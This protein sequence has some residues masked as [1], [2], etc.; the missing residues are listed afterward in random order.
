M[1]A[2]DDEN[3][4]VNGQL[5]E[6]PSS[7]SIEESAT[8][9]DSDA[10]DPNDRFH[11]RTGVSCVGICRPCFAVHLQLA[12]LVKI[13]CLQLPTQQGTHMPICAQAYHEPGSSPAF[14]PD[15]HCY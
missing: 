13:A 15:C 6:E 9:E 8:E 1:V 3:V 11:V 5:Q 12:S 7:E 10:D 14:E 2:P 4:A